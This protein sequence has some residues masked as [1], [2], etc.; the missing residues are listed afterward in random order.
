MFDSLTKIWDGITKSCHEFA[1]QVYKS[2]IFVI[3]PN[4]HL[5][6]IIYKHFYRFKMFD[7][8][9]VCLAKNVHILEVMPPITK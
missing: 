6:L 3:F 7:T 1:K 9:L 5:N 8:I 4:F 2:K